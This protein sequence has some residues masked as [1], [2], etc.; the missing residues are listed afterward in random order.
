MTL[1]T[2]KGR[3]RFGCF[4]FTGQG[5]LPNNRWHLRG[6]FCVDHAHRESWCAGL[7]PLLGTCASGVLNQSRLIP[8]GHASIEGPDA[9][10]VAASRWIEPQDGGTGVADPC[11]VFRG[12][13]RRGDGGEQNDCRSADD[14]SRHSG[15]PI[16]PVMISIPAHGR[17]ELV[18]LHLMS[19][20]R[21]MSSM[22]RDV[23]TPDCAFHRE[24]S[25]VLFDPIE[26]LP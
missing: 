19:P 9:C 18:I 26:R 5:R 24:I 17:W 7:E 23:L 13:G 25:Y 11:R 22:H 2:F 15:P 12:M 3:I 10:V 20:L 14:Q 4:C 16:V 21:S 6:L 8:F 1:L